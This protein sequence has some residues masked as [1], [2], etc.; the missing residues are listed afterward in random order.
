MLPK[1]LRTVKPLMFECPLFS[2]RLCIIQIYLL[3]SCRNKPGVMQ[4]S[5]LRRYYVAI[6]KSID[7]YKQLYVQLSIAH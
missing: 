7:V 3:T 2:R 5:T 1:R 6:R 4:V